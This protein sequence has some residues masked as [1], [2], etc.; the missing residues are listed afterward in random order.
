[1]FCP[2]ISSSS[3]RF[4]QKSNKVHSPSGP[5]L[6][7]ALNA[8]K[9]IEEPQTHRASDIENHLAD[10]NLQLAVSCRRRHRASPS[11][12][13]IV[14]EISEFL[15]TLKPVCYSKFLAGSHNNTR[16]TMTKNSKIF[17]IIVLAGMVVN[18]IL[19]VFLILYYFDFL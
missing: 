6:A 9:P 19:A 13:E 16:E 18:I 11:M 14:S 7:G 5:D 17:D 2:I 10:L 1:M 4:D 8:S 3:D 15:D 12:I